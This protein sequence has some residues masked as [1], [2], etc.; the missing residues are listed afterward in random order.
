[1][2]MA[3]T[4]SKASPAKWRPRQVYIMAI[5]CLL[6]GLG[7]GYL[8]RGSSSP[9]ST[10]AA[11]PTSPDPH[12]AAMQGGQMP[13]LDQMRHM[14]E[15]KAQPLL[16][17]LK[18]N[19]KDAG[20]LVQLGDIYNSTHQFGQAADYYKQALE[21]DPKNVGVRTRMAS[22]LYFSGQTDEAIHQLE[23]SLKYDPKH[24]GT[25]FNL[26]MIRWKGKDDGPGAIAA[27]QQ[28]LQDYPK[29]PD[30][31]PPRETVKKLIEEAKSHPKSS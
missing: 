26:G 19:P 20:T 4:E 14:A 16:A 30:D 10:A 27:W 22:C 1:M 3:T 9:A 31:L 23:Q 6:L 29:L 5:V 11:T 24:A 25:L 17:Q 21:V 8:A 2:A 15:T 7:M 18:T 12:A 13:S 28:L